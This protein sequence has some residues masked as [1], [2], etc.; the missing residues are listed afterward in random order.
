MSTSTVAAPWPGSPTSAWPASPARRSAPLKVAIHSDDRT[1]S[2]SGPAD[3]VMHLAELAVGM[4]LQVTS[5]DRSSGV[6]TLELTAR[7]GLASKTE[8]LRAHLR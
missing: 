5:H 1:T 3:Q 7:R 8:R 2:L 4:G 6:F